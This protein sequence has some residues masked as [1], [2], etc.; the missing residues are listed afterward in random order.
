MPFLPSFGLNT[1]SQ[2]DVGQPGSTRR[3]AGDASY[4]ANWTDSRTELEEV[5]TRFPQQGFSFSDVLGWSGNIVTWTG[6][7]FCKTNAVYI[8]IASELSEYL[9]GSTVNLVTGVRAAVDPAKMKPDQL[10]DPL[11][12]IVTLKARV[13]D[14][15]WTSFQIPVATTNFAVVRQLAIVFRGFE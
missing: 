3:A 12:N 9:T 14:V 5:V 8:T 7:M 13:I 10:V 2:M 15:Q 6:T 4:G 1:V 11:G